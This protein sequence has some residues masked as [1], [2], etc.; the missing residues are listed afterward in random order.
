MPTETKLPHALAMLVRRAFRTLRPLVLVACALAL[1]AGAALAQQDRIVTKDGKEK[2]AKVVSEDYDG[3]TLAVDGGGTTGLRWKTIESVRYASADKYYRALDAFA[4]GSPDEALTQLEALAGDS[5]LRPVLRHGVLFHLARTYQKVGNAD[6]ALATYEALL[7]AFPKTRYL[8]TV[9]ANL[10]ALYRA[11]GT[12][13]AGAKTLETRLTAAQGGSNDPTLQAGIGVLRGAILEEQGKHADAQRVFES[14]ASLSGADAEVVAAAKLGLARCAQ[15]AG[16]TSDADTRYRELVLAEAPNEVLAGA[17]NGLGDL[18]FEPALQKRD[19]LGLREALFAYLRGVVLYV[20][21]RE[22]AT[23][24]YERA[25]AGTSKAF[26]ALGELET[27]AERKKTFLD[28]SRRRRD[29]LASNYPQ[30]RYLKDL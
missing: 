24:E 19:P 3:L 20:P 6:K 23:D 21:G 5:K 26:K 22:G 14:T 8:L 25:L 7:E 2:I 4:T 30:S 17:W 13:G 11:K 10:I 12:V 29:E 1:G 28:R 9:G 27:D 15:R 18:A 16:R